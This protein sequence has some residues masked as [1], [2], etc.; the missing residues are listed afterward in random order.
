[1]SDDLKARLVRS[2][3]GRKGRRALLLG[4]SVLAASTMGFATPDL[5]AAVHGAFLLAVEHFPLQ[6]ALA[7]AHDLF[8]G[9]KSHIATVGIGIHEWATSS[10]LELARIA[11][12]AVV[13]MKTFMGDAVEASKELFTG[14]ISTSR[15]FAAFWFEKAGEAIATTMGSLKSDLPGAVK[16]AGEKIGGVIV[17]VAEIWGVYKAMEE[18]HEWSLRRLG[19]RAKKQEPDTEAANV[20]NVGT[21]QIN[22]AVA[23]D[24]AAQAA[25]VSLAEALRHADID[26]PD[27]L[28]RK[29]V[30]AVGLDASGTSSP[31]KP[32]RAIS[33]SD[34]GIVWMSDTFRRDMSLR[35]SSHLGPDV[36]ATR[37]ASEDAALNDRIEGGIILKQTPRDSVAH[38]H[39]LNL[40]G[41][42][43]DS[44][45]PTLM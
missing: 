10:G 30:D 33:A 39:D 6:D 21:I 26:I 34:P 15:D 8:T 19:R 18:A 42:Q 5:V 44:S 3:S 16:A 14:T 7:T 4:G 43:R 24:K 28:S 35:I 2:L 32:P 17:A 22:I 11:R 41:P 27:S 38:F 13:E 36:F 29:I 23:G 40:E 1:M 25:T 31:T 12:D 45:G 37:N 20:V 9:A